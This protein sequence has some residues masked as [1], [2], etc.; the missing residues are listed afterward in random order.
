MKTNISNGVKFAVIQTGGKQY[1]VKPGDVI[2]VEKLEKPKKGSIFVF[3]KILLAVEGE[4][5]IIGKPFLEKTRVEAEWK[6]EAKAKKITILRYK[7][8]TR[9]SKKK[10]HRQP[11]TEVLIKN[12]KV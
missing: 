8:K 10:G 6:K 3:D 11:Y 4:K 5:I 9:Y 1:I 2:K 12:I 7:S